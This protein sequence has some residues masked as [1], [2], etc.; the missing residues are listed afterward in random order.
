MCTTLIPSSFAFKIVG[1]FLK[2]FRGQ[3]RAT[4]AA[5]AR[6]AVVPNYDNP[7][8]QA[9]KICS[10]RSFFRASL[11]L[12]QTTPPPPP[13]TCFIVSRPPT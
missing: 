12:P 8:P 4:T 9:I 2:G 7:S 3:T 6:S 13:N 1:A 10:G 5:L 11:K